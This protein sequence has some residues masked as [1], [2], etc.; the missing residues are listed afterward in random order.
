MNATRDEFAIPESER[1]EQF[2]SIEHFQNSHQSQSDLEQEKLR[3]E[4][5]VDGALVAALYGEGGYGGARE[6][7]EA[8]RD[9]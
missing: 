2:E 5:G 9:S 6:I 7:L 3:V 1:G 8:M 4:F